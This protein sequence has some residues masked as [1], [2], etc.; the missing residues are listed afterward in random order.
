[1][2]FVLFCFFPPP[3]DDLSRAA[4]LRGAQRRL[5][6]VPPTEPVRHSPGWDGHAGG[7]TNTDVTLHDSSL[8]SSQLAHSDSFT[9]SS[10][11][12]SDSTEEGEGAGASSSNTPSVRARVDALLAKH[13]QGPPQSPVAPRSGHD[14]I[15]GTGGWT[16]GHAA[17][18]NEGD[19]STLYP[20]ERE[21]DFLDEPPSK[22]HKH[23]AHGRH[24]HFKDEDDWHSSSDDDE[25][26]G[27]A[28]ISAENIETSSFE[29][30]EWDADMLF[31]EMKGKKSPESI[32]MEIEDELRSAI[33]TSFNVNL[34]S[35][36]GRESPIPDSQVDYPDGDPNRPGEPVPFEYNSYPSQALPELRVNRFGRVYVA[37]VDDDDDSLSIIS[38]RTEPEST[39]EEDR[40]GDYSGESSSSSTEVDE[41]QYDVRMVAKLMA[42]RQSPSPSQGSRITSSPTQTSRTT[43]SP[44]HHDAKDSTDSKA[45]GKH[46]PTNR[47][48]NKKN[49]ISP[50]TA[51][52]VASQKQPSS[53][54]GKH[55]EN[56]QSEKHSRKTPTSDHHRG[57]DSSVPKSAAS[58]S[59][60]TNKERD[61]K[62]SHSHSKVADGDKKLEGKGTDKKPSSKTGGSQHKDDIIVAQTAQKVSSSRAKDGGKEP[63]SSRTVDLDGA[64]IPE[65]A[66]QRR[67]TITQMA[68]DAHMQEDGGTDEDE[69]AQIFEQNKQFV[70]EKEWCE[71]MKDSSGFPKKESKNVK[72]GGS[73]AS[74]G[75]TGEKDGDGNTR[76]LSVRGVAV[77]TPAV[78]T[79]VQA[80]KPA[81]KPDDK[82]Q[83]QKSKSVEPKVDKNSVKKIPSEP[84][85]SAQKT[86]PSKDATKKLQKP[87]DRAPVAVTATVVASTKTAK[88]K[89][90]R[91]KNPDSP[92]DETHTASV[93]ELQKMFNHPPSYMM[94][95]KVK[96]ISSDE[97]EEDSRDSRD[98]PDGGREPAVV[99][100]KSSEV[101]AVVKPKVVEYREVTVDNDYL[102]FDQTIPNQEEEL[103]AS[104]VDAV[105]SA[106]P[107]IKQGSQQSARSP[108]SDAKI[109]IVDR[110]SLREPV[111]DLDSPDGVAMAAATKVAKVDA[112]SLRQP[113]TDLD[114]PDDFA[115][116]TPAVSIVVTRDDGVGDTQKDNTDKLSA[117][118][119]S[120]RTIDGVD[121]GQ[122]LSDGSPTKSVQD[123]VIK[124]AVDSETATAVSI[125]TN[126]HVA[127][128]TNNNDISKPLSLPTESEPMI[129][130]DNDIRDSVTTETQRA[131]APDNAAP[132]LVA[133]QLFADSHKDKHTDDDMMVIDVAKETEDLLM[134]ESWEGGHDDDDETDDEDKPLKAASRQDFA[135]STP[136][137]GHATLASAESPQQEKESTQR[138]V[139]NDGEMFAGSTPTGLVTTGDYFPSHDHEILHDA[140]VASPDTEGTLTPGIHVHVAPAAAGSDLSQ[141][142]PSKA[143]VDGTN[144]GE[145]AGISPVVRRVGKR[146]NKSDTHRESFVFFD[147]SNPSLETPSLSFP[148]HNHEV[149]D[150]L[151]DDSAD[152]D[153]DSLWL[154]VESQRSRIPSQEDAEDIDDRVRNWLGLESPSHPDML[155][156]DNVKLT[157]RGANGDNTRSDVDRQN[158]SM[159]LIHADSRD[160]LTVSDSI[161]PVSAMSDRDSAGSDWGGDISSEAPVVPPDYPLNG[162]SPLQPFK[163]IQT[164]D[165]DASSIESSGMGNLQEEVFAALSNKTRPKSLTPRN[166]ST[167]SSQV[168]ESQLNQESLIAPVTNQQV[169]SLYLAKS[170]SAGVSM[171]SLDVLVD[172]A[173]DTADERAHPEKLEEDFA[174]SLDLGPVVEGQEPRKARNLPDR[175]DSLRNKREAK[176]NNSDTNHSRV[177]DLSTLD[178][179]SPSEK[180]INPGGVALAGSDPNP[181]NPSSASSTPRMTTNPTSLPP[182]ISRPAADQLTSPARSTGN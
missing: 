109:A 181:L 76:R 178:H 54:K 179:Y 19:S 79:Q 13:K 166:G 120:H 10:S 141:P 68:L 23:R 106:P 168:S 73:D 69:F 142:K 96:T 11:K 70:T 97:S 150:V 59:E 152:A 101:V 81:P 104:T 48:S 51:A 30:L 167:D 164:T 122:Q 78:T 140:V 121:P 115:M 126:D 145:L 162:H 74:V 18:L 137:H 88:R 123:P 99:V 113:V 1:M 12:A 180:V 31:P 44:K 157:D 107:A 133:K 103:K 93:N 72:A 127:M 55:A 65:W 9:S 182:S 75:V 169:A 28:D 143:G 155:T 95:G 53:A 16:A 5:L 40:S 108:V 156:E 172:D 111:T 132:V 3:D 21:G 87:S 92:V 146:A 4:E 80:T 89:S 135:T 46:T 37:D 41:D 62:H 56:T 66:L 174:L 131:V 105:R 6:L 61:G 45:S 138:D 35:E 85:Q 14:D 175:V 8:L 32:E 125:V 86:T 71:V 117:I 147:S 110:E 100:A 82:I 159:M 26:A 158:E 98:S 43:P 42:K 90:A 58:S 136:D 119:D 22:V 154:R 33:R 39:S 177:K 160:S 112:K 139:E 170:H 114:A 63:T 153:P 38:E 29:D 7:E 148:S 128:E 118:N 25:G 52:V 124:D 47:N 67:D 171:A 57:A 49:I 20:K 176:D 34:I 36:N 77:I 83:T 27:D 102:H 144:S 130:S 163:V 161:T 84:T 94:P 165:L 24:A 173:S 15:N 151:S 91:N 129:A 64:E 60:K 149:L 50:S 134:D 17:A 116:V 2:H